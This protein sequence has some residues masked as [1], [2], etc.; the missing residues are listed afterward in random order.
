MSALH[1]LYLVRHATS[2]ETRAARF[3][4]TTGGQDVPDCAGL[5]AA[6][7]RSAE[8]LGAHLPLPD[9]V[10]SSWAARARE[11]AALAGWAAE[12]TA[13]LAECDFGSWAG[14]EV[15]EIA[16]ADPD[17]FAAWLADPTVGPADGEPLEQL[18]TRA[19][20]VLECG[21]AGTSIAVTHGGFIRAAVAEVLGLAAGALARIDLAPASVTVLHNDGTW[22]LVRLNWTPA[23]L[24][25][26]AATPQAV[27]P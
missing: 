26:A 11:T 3:P 18:R 19:R 4:V 16:A 27:T 15:H 21:C 7:R 9:R 20:R 1:R 25:R 14:R 12:P 24:A 22:R 23:L 13:D 2:A 10:W 5:D 8:A 6:G 17:G